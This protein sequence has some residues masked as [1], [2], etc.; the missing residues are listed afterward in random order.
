MDVTTLILATR[1]KFLPQLLTALKHQTH[2]PARVIISDDN[3]EQPFVAAVRGIANTPL[4]RDL[5]LLAVPGPR[6]GGLNNIRHLL[7]VWGGQTELFHLLCDDDLI[8]PEFY[9]WH[10]AAQSAG[11]RCSISRRWSTDEIGQPIGILNE[12]NEIRGSAQALISISGQQL[13]PAVVPAANNWLGEISNVVMHRDLADL[14]RDLSFEG[15][16]YDGLDDIG[17]FL[18]ASA[19]QPI[20]VITHFLSMFRQHADQN[21]GN[22]NRRI[23]KLGHV[24][25][26]A[27]AISSQRA[28]LLTPEQAQQCI[29][30]VAHHT[31]LKYATQP[32]MTEICAT[33][34][35]LGK[36]EAGAVDAFLE[37]WARFVAQGR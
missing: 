18:R 21:T 36:N 27:L 11:F 3:P 32:D 7:D 12:P 23:I 24:A 15:I 8:Y 19:R 4:A 22:Q 6:Q 35:R 25:W 9:S 17:T 33:L 5:N 16:A 20:A 37:C 29:S 30:S 14:Y 10:V 2:R 31:V 26:I 34:T 28:G 13:F 1:P